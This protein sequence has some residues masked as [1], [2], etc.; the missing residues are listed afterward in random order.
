[1]RAA[2]TWDDYS[3]VAVLEGG[4]VTQAK[5]LD[6]LPAR[7][8]EVVKLMTNETVAPDAIELWSPRCP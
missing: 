6:Q 8:V 4:G 5:R 7:L 2:V 1:M 3:W